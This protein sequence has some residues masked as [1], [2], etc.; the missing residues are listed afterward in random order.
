MRVLLPRYLR[1]FT[2]RCSGHRVLHYV[3]DPTGLATHGVGILI[4]R[5]FGRVPEAPAL[6]EAEY[7]LIGD[8]VAYASPNRL[9][10]PYVF[11]TLDAVAA[12]ALGHTYAKRA[13]AFYDR[14][15]GND[16]RRYRGR[17]PFIACARCDRPTGMFLVSDEEWAR[18]GPK[19]RDQVLCE[20]CYREVVGH[21]RSAV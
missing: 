17:M 4:T 9:T 6:S 21:S 19:W 15:R 7:V 5:P 13:R 18:V 1:R 16:V 14:V 2:S 12:R 10:T 8:W 3:G 11:A 20:P